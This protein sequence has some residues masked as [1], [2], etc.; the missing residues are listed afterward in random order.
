MLFGSIVAIAEPPK[1]RF[2]KPPLAVSSPTE[3]AYEQESEESQDAAANSQEDMEGIDEILLEEPVARENKTM[4][5]EILPDPG[6]FAAGAVSGVVSRTF[7]APLD[8][9]KV[10]L[11]ANIGPAKGSVAAA[12]KGDVSVA[13]KK[14]GQPLVDASKELWRAGGIRSLFAGGFFVPL[15]FDV[16]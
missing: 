14:L 9:I 13:A 16:R 11:I 10:Y 2:P 6:Y 1:G 8:R 4:L 3:P 12:V 7:T 15:P 5:T